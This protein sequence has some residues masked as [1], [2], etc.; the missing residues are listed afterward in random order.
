MVRLVPPLPGVGRY[1]GGLLARLEVVVQL[2]VLESQEPPP[3]ERGKPPSPRH[4]GVHVPVVDLGGVGLREEVGGVGRSRNLDVARGT[5]RLRLAH[6]VVS[7]AG[8]PRL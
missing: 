4:D 7:D 2:H 3:Q 6:E 1:A 5:D 8:V